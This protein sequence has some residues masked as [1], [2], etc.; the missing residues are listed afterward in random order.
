MSCALVTGVQTCAHPILMGG[1]SPATVL[2]DPPPSLLADLGRELARIHAVPLEK[3]PAAIPLMDTGAALAELKA[4][5]LSYG[6]DRPAIALAIKWCE[7]HLPDPARPVLVHGDYRMGNV[8]VDGDGLAAV[9]DWE[10]AH[11]GGAP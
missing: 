4:R 10:L 11:R 3:V 1:V 7:E 8:I 5:F 2:A 6:G 9:L